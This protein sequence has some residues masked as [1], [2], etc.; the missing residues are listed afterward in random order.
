[1]DEMTMDIAEKDRT[2]RRRNLF[3]ADEMIIEKSLDEHNPDDALHQE[4][5]FI[6]R[7]LG[8]SESDTYLKELLFVELPGKHNT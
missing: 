8:E 4:W 1:V 2:A 3:L 7:V 5:E 6:Q